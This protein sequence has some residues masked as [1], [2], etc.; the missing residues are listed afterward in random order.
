MA[1]I[2][3]APR[4]T[5]H[6]A[7]SILRG[8]YCSKFEIGFEIISCACVV[9]QIIVQFYLHLQS[10]RRTSIKKLLAISTGVM[11]CKALHLNMLHK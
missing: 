6:E 11:R 3:P 10:R 4:V 8:R 1:L 2:E 7:I 5:G 9:V